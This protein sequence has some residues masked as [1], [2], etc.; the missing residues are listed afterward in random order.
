V[1]AAFDILDEQGLDAL[2]MANVA[3]RVGFT[4]MAV[5]RHVNGRDELVEAAVGE[6]LAPMTKKP[7]SELQW[8]DG[9]VQWMN[10]LRS[11]LRA[12]PWAISLLGSRKGAG[13]SLQ[14][15][16]DVLYGHLG[17]SPL[18]LRD[19]GRAAA[20]TGRVTI[21]ILIEELAIPVEE[22]LPAELRVRGKDATD[23]RSTIDDDL[24]FA[25][26]IDLTRR[27]LTRLATS[28]VDDD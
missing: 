12:H 8:L 4:T 24:L 26:T 14:E 19:R 22:S 9:V 6:A 25:D 3:D 23:P 11:C 18:N 13:P 10:S 20:W 17:R 15:A 1:H 5:Y 2:T 21:G 16:F 28:A 27:F 7:G